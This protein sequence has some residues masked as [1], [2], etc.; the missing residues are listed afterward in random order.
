MSAYPINPWG[1]RNRRKVGLLGGSFNPA[2]GGHV[3]ISLNGLR[4]LGL[5]EIWWLVSPQNPLKQAH[6][7]QP[8]PERVRHAR[9]VARHPRLRVSALESAFGTRYTIDTLAVLQKRFPKMRF[10][11]LMGADN[12]A[13]IPRWRRWTEIFHSLPVA[14]FDR[15]PYS[16]KGLAGRA[17]LRY[18]SFRL[19]QNRARMI[20]D[21]PPVAWVFLHIRRNPLSSTALRGR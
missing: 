9:M 12:L 10:V 7:T 5:D 21:M 18:R 13:Q 6:Q 2:H 16:Y 3:Q 17:A 8:L 11:W 4:L 15:A 1:N 19:A 20:A 14:V